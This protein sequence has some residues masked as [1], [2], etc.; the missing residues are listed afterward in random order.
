M[1]KDR[2]EIIRGS[3]PNLITPP[4]G[5]RFH[6]RCPAVFEECGWS[7]TEVGDE[8][9]AVIR[10]QGWPIDAE[11]I[12]MQ[13]EGSTEL[14]IRFP[15]KTA[16]GEAVEWTRRAVDGGRSRPAIGAVVSVEIKT[17]QRRLIEFFLSPLLKYGQESI[18]ER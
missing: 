17:G 18:R 1:R 5:C 4:P 11:A 12:T 2:L 14:R 10:E 15:E 16:A 9:R 13:P 8:I 7:P 6:P 3:V